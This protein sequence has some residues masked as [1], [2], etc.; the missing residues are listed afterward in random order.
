M[1]LALKRLIEAKRPD[2]IVVHKGERECIIIGI[3]VSRDT[4]VRGKKRECGEVSRFEKVNQ[5]D[6]EYGK[7]DSF[8]YDCVCTPKHHKENG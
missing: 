7:W 8:T 1:G 3:A 6:F 4:K 5:E 2:V